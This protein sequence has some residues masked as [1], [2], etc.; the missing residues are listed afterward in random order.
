M[1]TYIYIYIYIDGHRASDWPK[2]HTW[3]GKLKISAKGIYKLFYISLYVYDMF[4]Y[5]CL[6]IFKYIYIYE[7]TW[8]G[9][10]KILAKG[11]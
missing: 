4:I 10:L 11:V 8:A 1:Y 7:H 9:K 2:E 6:Y 3:A 5:I